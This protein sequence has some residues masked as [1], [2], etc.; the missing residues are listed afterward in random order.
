[1]SRLTFGPVGAAV[2][3]SGAYLLTGTEVGR[4]RERRIPV[5]L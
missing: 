1:M 2:V 5:N 4:L 3:T